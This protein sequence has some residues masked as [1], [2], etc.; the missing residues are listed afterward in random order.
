MDES[1]LL[2]GVLRSV[3]GGRRKRSRRAMRYLGTR[4]AVRRD[5]RFDWRI[6]LSNPNLLLTAA[7]VAWGIFETLA[8]KAT[9]RRPRPRRRRRCRMPLRRRRCHRCRWLATPSR[10]DE[11]SGAP[12]RAPCDFCCVRR[13]TRERPGASRDSGSGADRRSG[14]T[15]SSRNWR[16]RAARRDRRGCQR[17]HRTAARSTC[18]HSVS[19]E[20]TNSRRAPNVS[21][22]RNSRTCS[23]SIRARFSSSNE[24][25]PA[26][27]CGAWAV[28]SR[29]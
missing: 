3:L 25:R 4:G 26:D 14:S 13:R 27:R 9:R 17:R 16:S 21:T 7:G 1:M 23:D 12:D 15:S 8:D 18:W 29:Q 22:W 19:F 6:L 28:G 10:A 11:R 24:M 2:N 20:A 5:A